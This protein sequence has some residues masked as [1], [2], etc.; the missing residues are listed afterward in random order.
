M[1]SELF[2]NRSINRTAA[3]TSTTRNTLVSVDNVLAITLSDA[4]ARTSISTSTTS[5]AIVCNLISHGK[6]LHI[7]F[8]LLL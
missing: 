8:T 3:C 2:L 6:H 4:S 7:N 1:Y 5:D